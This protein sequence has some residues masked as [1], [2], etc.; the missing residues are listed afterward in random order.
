MKM[1]PTTTLSL[2][3][4]PFE[5]KTLIVSYCKK[6][7]IFDKKE[8][9]RMILVNE[10]LASMNSILFD[11]LVHTRF[12]FGDSACHDECCY[13]IKNILVEMKLYTNG[14]SLHHRLIT[15]CLNLTLYYM[16]RT[17]NHTNTIDREIFV[18]L[19][20]TQQKL[21][22]YGYSEKLPHKLPLPPPSLV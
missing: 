21:I 1:K 22:T 13:Y 2:S 5:I 9:S 11:I 12:D 6:G 3:R 15:R 10:R 4:L 7:W 20:E 8:R 19:Y 18:M 14:Y 17:G 16:K